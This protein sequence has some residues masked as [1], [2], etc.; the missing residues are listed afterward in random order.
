[1]FFIGP[2]VVVFPLLVRDYYAAGVD[3]LSL[4]LMLFPLGTI[5]GSLVLRARG[6]GRKG[7]AA[8]AALVGGASVE[9]TIGLGVPYA[10]LVGLTLVW[11]LCGA[12]FINCSRTLFQEAAPDA[13]RGRVLAVYQLGFM[14]GAPV[15]TLLAGFAVAELGLHGTLLAAAGAMT[16]VVVVMATRTG[17][18][19]MR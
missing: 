19:R 3:A 12:V 1:V 10:A 14:G 7:G 4:V 16:T 15:G 13:E 6:I 17:T 8:L 9:A 2:Y 11:G 5:A 18:A